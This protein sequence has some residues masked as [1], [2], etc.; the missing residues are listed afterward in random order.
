MACSSRPR[1][2][3][4][5]GAW[6]LSFAIVALCLLAA[7]PAGAQ[8]VER[9]TQDGQ[10]KFSP[11]FRDQGR[12]VVFV[13]LVDPTLYRLQT[14]NL[15]DG[16]VTALHQDAPTSEF[17]PSCLTEGGCYAFLKTR[18]ALSVSMVIRDERGNDLG[19]V[20]PGEGF[21]GLR[22]PA[23]RADQLRVA[24]SLA[25]EGRQQIYSVRQDASDKQQLTNSR[26]INNWPAWSPD[27]ERI[28]FGSSRA[29]DFEIY[30]MREDGT[31][32]ERLTHSPGQDIRPRF[33][34]DGS[35]IAFTS[36]RDGNAEI[37]VMQADGSN[38]RRVTNHPDRDDYA[39]W[40]PD[41]KRLVLVSERDGLHDL[42]LITVDP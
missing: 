5:Q 15:A 25:E 33:S 12:Q 14:L 30:V 2:A 22:S 8:E 21:A 23:I 27:G 11:V 32:Q 35:R 39:D 37:Y 7:S 42:Y 3:A 16:T 36:H 10:L 19:E 31:G 28:V 29:D 24:Y 13:E 26:G 9:L 40:H 1:I 4:R 34:P 17:E 20:L 18:G 6:C 41:G 38:P